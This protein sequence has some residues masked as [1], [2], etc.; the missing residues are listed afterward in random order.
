MMVFWGRDLVQIYNDGYRPLI[1]DKHPAAFGQRAEDCFPEIWHVIGPMLHGVMD[2][3]VPTWEQ[4]QH[5]MLERADFAD[6]CYFTYTFSPVGTEPINGVFCVVMETTRQVIAERRSAL[7]RDLATSLAGIGSAQE[8][9]ATAATVLGRHP[10]D[11]RSGRLR[12]FPDDSTPWDVSW[13]Q[14]DDLDPGHVDRLLTATGA[15][16]FARLESAI[17][18]GAAQRDGEAAL[19]AQ[20]IHSPGTAATAAIVMAINHGVPVDVDY[21][22]FLARVADT[23]GAAHAV[24]EGFASS[25]RRTRA[26]EELDRAKTAFLSNISHEFRTPLTLLLGPLAAAQADERVPRDTRE[27]LAMA[28]RNARRVLKL[29][30]S[31]LDISRLEAGRV[32]ATFQPTDLA[33]ATADVVSVFRSAAQ[34]AGLDLRIDCPPL[35]EPVYVDREMWEQIVTNLCANALKFTETG[36]IR[37]RLRRTESWARLDVIDT[38]IGIAADDVPF[39]FDRFRRAGAADTPSRPG[40]G[41][42]LALVRELVDLHR[43]DVT[44]ASTEGAG[45]TFGVTIPFGTAHVSPDRLVAAQ[46]VAP[47]ALSVSAGDVLDAFDER[48]PDLRAAVRD[49]PD[50]DGAPTVWVVDDNADMRAYVSVLLAPHANVVSFPDAELVLDALTEQV[51]DLVLSDVMLPGRSGLALLAAVRSDP[52]I[53]EVPVILLSARAGEEATIEG[54]QAGA[55]DYLVKPFTARELISRIRSNLHLA[56]LRREAG[57]RALRHATQLEALT[58]AATRIISAEPADIAATLEAFV[59]DIAGVASCAVTLAD[60]SGGAVPVR[61][62]QTTIPLTADDGTVLGTIEITATGDGVDGEDVKLVEQL[63]LIAG[64]RIEHLRR[65]RRERDVSHALQRSLLPESLPR[66]ERFEMVARYRPAAATDEVGGDWYDALMLPDGRL[67][68]TVGD[69]MGHDLAAAVTMGQI[70]LLLR[71]WAAASASPADLCSTVNTLLPVVGTPTMATMIVA[72]I[73]LGTGKAS[74]VNAGHHAPILRTAERTRRLTVKTS[75]ALGVLPHTTYRQTT[76]V[77]PPGSTLF[78]YTDGLTER[79][80]ESPQTSRRRLLRRCADLD[81]TDL[82][83]AVDVLLDLCSADA[84]DDIAIMALR[85]P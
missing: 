21:R 51:P 43:G 2:T 50:G 27:S 6:E 40:S 83:T 64:R 74:I 34:A 9:F 8:L 55:D 81:L 52:A 35:G 18:P 68:V 5:L 85:R 84:D 20:P 48:E 45:S 49:R 7:L 76:T 1:G 71:S 58:A 56:G 72:F 30:N 66:S 33:A 39:I 11:V 46:A 59:T 15:D 80:R 53:A 14:A 10:R 65:Y 12:V 25:A 24:T 32:A 73:D 69:V 57:A 70:R 17:T 67:M 38:G 16:A 3:G 77:L 28:D 4:D 23:I 75:M 62:G 31:L 61:G 19:A 79:R 13:G 42:G 60:P 37:V 22:E 82:D 26:L 63:A 36:S 44:V 54:L 41:L 29:V 78:I 47:R